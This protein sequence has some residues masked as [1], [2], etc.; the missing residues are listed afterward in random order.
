MSR[1]GDPAARRCASFAS[2][3]RL[4]SRAVFLRQATADAAADNGGKVPSSTFPLRV[5]P[6]PNPSL[7]ISGSLKGIWKEG[8]LLPFA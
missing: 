4:D 6:S 5:T 7:A 2:R 1:R 8:S 3:G